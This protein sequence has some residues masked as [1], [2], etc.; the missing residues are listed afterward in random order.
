MLKMKWQNKN[1]NFLRTENIREGCFWKK[2]RR[3]RKILLRYISWGNKKRIFFCIY[4]CCGVN[5][6]KNWKIEDGIKISDEGVSFSHPHEKETPPVFHD[7]FFLFSLPQMVQNLFI[8]FSGRGVLFFFIQD[9]QIFLFEVSCFIFAHMTHLKVFFI[10]EKWNFSLQPIWKNGLRWRIKK[11]KKLHN[12]ANWYVYSSLF[13]IN[14][15]HYLSSSFFFWNEVRNWT[16]EMKNDHLAPCHSL[17][18]FFFL[19]LFRVVSVGI[20]SFPILL[21]E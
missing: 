14:T 18:G 21:F 12:N 3:G 17:A 8:F 13:L 10:K 19:I 2:H 9:L 15:Q 5:F 4:V 7:T 6:L 11:R 20:S 1:L 16:W